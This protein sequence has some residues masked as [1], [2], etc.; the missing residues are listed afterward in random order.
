M[1]NKIMRAAL[2][3]PQRRRRAVTLRG[4][5]PKRREELMVADQ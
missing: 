1:T 2:R 3:R 5:A 4:R